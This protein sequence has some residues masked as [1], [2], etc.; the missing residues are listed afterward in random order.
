MLTKPSSTSAWGPLGLE[1]IQL[2]P[3]F[4]FASCI[5]AHQAF[6]Q[7]SVLLPASLE[8]AYLLK[9]EPVILSVLV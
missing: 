6:F 2:C 7:R 5:F 9:M 1:D 4:F 8:R 3:T